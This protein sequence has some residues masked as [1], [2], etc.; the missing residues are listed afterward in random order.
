MKDTYYA[1]NKQRVLK[2]ARKYRKLNRNVIR[3]R[4]QRLKLEVMTVYANGKLKCRNCNVTDLDVLVL[5]HINND[6]YKHVTA[7]GFRMGGARLYGFL[8]K[9]GYPKCVQVLCANCNLKKEVL[10]KQSL[11]YK[12]CRAPR[13]KR[14]LYYGT[15]R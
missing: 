8:K 9:S 15:S 13:Y 4:G 7:G 10:H 1:K 11:G 3:E 5:D 6:G 14:S 12:K 2:Q